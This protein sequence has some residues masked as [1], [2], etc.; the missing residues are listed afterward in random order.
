MGEAPAGTISLA[1]PDYKDRGGWSP[2]F[3]GRRLL[4][5]SWQLS[6]GPGILTCQWYFPCYCCCTF[7]LLSN[8]KKYGPDLFSWKVNKNSTQGATNWGH[9]KQIQFLFL[10]T[11]LS[12]L[13]KLVTIGSHCLLP[14]S[15]VFSFL[16]KF[17]Q[18][19]ESFLIW[20]V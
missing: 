19:L 11:A 8:G 14:S 3:Q 5:C 17:L 2:N 10:L 13:R 6:L 15:Q 20:H 18:I 9:T 16:V 12:S 1:C 7:Y 4:L